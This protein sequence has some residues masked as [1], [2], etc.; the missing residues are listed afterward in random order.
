MSTF[1]QYYVKSHL[2]HHLVYIHPINRLQIQK[3]PPDESDRGSEAVEDPRVIYLYLENPCQGSKDP[4]RR[5]QQS[6]DSFIRWEGLRL[7]QPKIGVIPGVIH[8]AKG[9]TTELTPKFDFP[10]FH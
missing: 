2:Q 5:I 9:Y 4:Q 10:A 7:L 3:G 6:E 1:K 8:H